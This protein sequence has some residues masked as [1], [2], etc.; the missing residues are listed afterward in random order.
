VVRGKPNGQPRG[1]YTKWAKGR[2]KRV[3]NLNGKKSW[4]IKN[5]QITF[6][7]EK[8]QQRDGKLQ[9]VSMEGEGRKG[10]KGDI[11]EVVVKLKKSC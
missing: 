9:M 3:K 2:K 10:G 6:E 5:G 4:E 11:V 1:S 8:S 7:E